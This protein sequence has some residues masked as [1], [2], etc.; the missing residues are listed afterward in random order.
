VRTH[1]IG[2]ALLSALVAGGSISFG[3]AVESAMNFGSRW[4]ET[5]RGM[6]GGK[7]ED[8]TSW[9]EFRQI[10]QLMEGRSSLSMGVSSGE[11]PV[12]DAPARP[13]WYSATV[14]SEPTLITTAQEAAN[15][16]E[17][18]NLASWSYV[19][20]KAARS[21]D[22]PIRA[23]LITPL[24]P[25]ARLCRW[26]VSNYLLATPSSVKLFLDHVANT[27]GCE[28]ILAPVAD[29]IQNRLRLSRMKVTGP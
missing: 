21:A 27:F 2:T 16:L 26:S 18:L 4:D 17:T 20:A 10:Q 28:P 23:W 6:A 24:H 1:V 19:P 22:E 11:L 9:F 7:T 29:P 15:A 3:A 14:S 8:E 25:M 5:L 12:P 13:F